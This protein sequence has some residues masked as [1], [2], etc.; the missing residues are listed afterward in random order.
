MYTL[1][2][3]S[4]VSWNE[5]YLHQFHEHSISVGVQCQEFVPDVQM[6][7]GP[8]PWCH[9]ETP[10]FVRDVMHHGCWCRR[11]LVF[12]VRDPLSLLELLLVFLHFHVLRHWRTAFSFRSLRSPLLGNCFCDFRHLLSFSECLSSQVTWYIWRGLCT[13]SLNMLTKCMLSRT[14]S[15][16]IRKVF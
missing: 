12:H 15:S 5:T 6:I 10:P 7:L 9:Q 1:L 14:I 3:I 8:G 16:L 11:G 4:N 13:Y 2:D